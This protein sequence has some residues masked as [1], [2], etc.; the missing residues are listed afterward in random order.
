MERSGKR[1]IRPPWYRNAR[2]GATGFNERSIS[3]VNRRLERGERMN[4]RQARRAAA[5]PRSRR[6]LVRKRLVRLGKRARQTRLRRQI[7][8]LNGRPIPAFHRALPRRA[9]GGV[10]AKQYRRRRRRAS[11]ERDQQ[12][13]E[14]GGLVLK[15]ASKGSDRPLRGVEITL[16][17]K[18]VTQRR[19]RLCR[20]AVARRSRIVVA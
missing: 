11:I 17:R 20:D 16:L 5:D 6:F 19:Q 8:R 3:T 13:R 18:P 12:R 7:E 14:A 4:R 10:A 1:E 9:S 2:A 15:L